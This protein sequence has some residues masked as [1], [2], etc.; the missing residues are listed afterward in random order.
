M[1]VNPLGQ[2]NLLMLAKSFTPTK[3]KA[4]ESHSDININFTQ[5]MSPESPVSSSQGVDVPEVAYGTQSE[6][7][8]VKPI[9]A[10]YIRKVLDTILDCQEETSGVNVGSENETK[11][12]QTNDADSRR[13]SQ[14]VVIGGNK[15]VQ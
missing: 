3:K 6:P 10:K 9:K 12:G 2:V 7:K 13:R 15:R 5:S 1:H 11:R 4:R 14:R 8:P